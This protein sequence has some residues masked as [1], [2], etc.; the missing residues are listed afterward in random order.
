VDRERQH[1]LLFATHA[2]TFRLSGEMDDQ[3]VTVA[4]KKHESMKLKQ[5]VHEDF[6]TKIVIETTA[7]IYIS[8]S[9]PGLCY[10]FVWSFPC[11]RLTRV[12]MGYW[13][14]TKHS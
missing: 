8:T 6:E 11:R 9:V 5:N 13:S 10:T 12:L 2:C 14:Q 1:G 4:V 7:Y 3:M